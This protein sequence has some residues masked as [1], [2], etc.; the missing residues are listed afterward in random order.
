[1]IDETVRNDELPNSNVRETV[2]R[3]VRDLL[4]DDRAAFD[5]VP[6]REPADEDVTT[7]ADQ[8]GGTDAES[9]T[10]AAGDEASS[11]TTE[12]DG[13]AATTEDGSRADDDGEAD[14]ASLG[15]FA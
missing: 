11:E 14:H 15:D 6:D 13:T 4:E 12:A 7:V 9:A 1:G 3:R 2:E 10:A 8:L 5:P